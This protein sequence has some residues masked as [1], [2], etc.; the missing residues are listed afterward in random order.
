MPAHAQETVADVCGLDR[1]GR[2]LTTISDARTA[3]CETTST[4]PGPEIQGL[5]NDSLAILD[6]I[7]QSGV[8]VRTGEYYQSLDS[9][10]QAT[11]ASR[12]LLEGH[13]GSE[14]S[15]FIRRY[16]NP[17]ARRDQSAYFE[18]IKGILASSSVGR[19]AMECF[20]TNSPPF[21]SSE[22]RFSAPDQQTFLGTFSVE[23]DSDEKF[24]KVLRFDL[25][26]SSPDRAL[27]L[28][29]H[30]MMHACDAVSFAHHHNEIEAAK[31]RSQ[32]TVSEVAKIVSRLQA[33][34]AGQ[35]GLKR[36]EKTR[37]LEQID[38]YTF[39]INSKD[40]L[41][42]YVSPDDLQ[43]LDVAVRNRNDAA[44]QIDRV[45]R[46]T[47]QNAAISE[48][49]VYKWIN[50]DFFKELARQSP[51]YFCQQLTPS[52]FQGGIATYGE[53]R[54]YLEASINNRTFLND[55]IRSYVQAGSY[56]PHSFYEQQLDANG[57]VIVA[58]SFDV[59]TQ[60]KLDSAFEEALTEAYR[61]IRD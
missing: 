58:P 59:L 29:A 38:L 12:D 60:R 9:L 21:K 45:N 53:S 47:D 6:R 31:L 28:V 26:N 33:E 13:P 10:A 48:L 40:D 8:D 39:S 20:S 46:A 14:L 34:V 25:V 3:I 49:K 32:E 7:Q 1:S 42:G 61:L 2:K 52:T 43:I 41:R 16:Q 35:R 51:R 24:R 54:S 55:L 11:N 22:V 44:R 37:I 27:S 4:S 18:D 19:K 57:A 23:K 36:R 30:E 15:D 56:D 50:V 17:E 5:A